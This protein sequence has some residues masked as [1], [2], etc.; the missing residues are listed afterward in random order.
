MYASLLSGNRAVNTWLSCFTLVSVVDKEQRTCNWQYSQLF[1]YTTRTVIAVKLRPIELYVGT[2]NIIGC[3]DVLD[4]KSGFQ[5][6]EFTNIDVL[7]SV[8][9]QWLP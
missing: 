3:S 1:C 2:D 4:L 8:K 5:R 6:Q 7:H 9:L